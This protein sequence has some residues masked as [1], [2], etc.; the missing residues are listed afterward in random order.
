MEIRALEKTDLKNIHK[1]NNQIEFMRLWFEEPYESLDEL[2]NLYEKHIHDS[3][4]RR[5]VIDVDGEFAG[6]VELMSIDYL[7][8]NCEIQIVILREFQGKGLAQ[9]ALEK[10]IE[11]AFS[12]LNLHKIYLYVDVN[13]ISAIHIYKKLGFKV[14]GTMVQ[15]FYTN[16]SYKDSHFMGLLK[17]QK[18]K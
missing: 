12:V 6:I 16:G 4:E 13:N 7:H 9:L 15:Q 1:I 14:E 11:Y 8:R 2:T 18:Y 5:F 17:S 10:G 3:S